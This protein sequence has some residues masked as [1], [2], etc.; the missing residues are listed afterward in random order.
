[1]NSK[2]SLQSVLDEKHAV[3]A[4]LRRSENYLAQTQQL[5]RTGSFGWTPSTGEVH[6]SDESFRIYELDRNIKPTVEVVLQR[7]HPDDRAFV[8]QAIGETSRGEKELDLTYRLLMADGSVKYVQVLSRTVKNAAGD[9]EV[10]GALMDV[11]ERKVQEHAQ[12]R[13]AAIVSSS[14]AAIVGKTLDGVVTSWNAGAESIFGY[15]AHEMIGQS[16]TRIIPPELQKEEKEI[17]RRIRQGD[18]IKN[19]ETVRNCKDGRRIDISLIIS[20]VLDQSGNV[21][22]ASKIARDITAEKRAEAE[23]QQIQVELARVARVSTVGELTAAIAHELNQPLAGVVNSGNACLRWLC[24]EPPDI[25]AARKSGER[26]V[27]AGER[28]AEVI[29]RVRALVEKAPPQ[30]E[31]FNINDAIAEV[32]AL[33]PGEIQ[34]NSISLRTNFANEMPFILADRIQ[35]QQVILSLVLNAIEAMSGVQSPRD[36]LVASAKSDSD[37]GVLVTVLDSG[38]GLDQ[39]SLDRLFEPFFTTKAQGMGIGLAVS[40][41][42]IQAHGGLLWARP[43]SPRGAVFTFSVPAE[44]AQVS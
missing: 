42:I 15:N 37:D 9:L 41:T 16:I 2:Q 36:L 32:F 38:T 12:A 8:R 17:L 10:I 18:R 39:N 20:P 3:E 34:R 31:Q 35:L 25:S 23:L 19:Y 4:S 33:I 21:V 1:M 29:K 6:W 14:D 43:N 11:T 5:S 27:A 13:L 28:A 30:R 22:G 44:G 7:I 24:S 26:V 40:R